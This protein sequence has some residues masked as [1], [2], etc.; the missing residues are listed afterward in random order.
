MDL[1]IPTHVLEGISSRGGF[2]D[3]ASK[4]KI[5]ILRNGKPL[6]VDRGGKKSQYFRYSDMI[7]GKHPESNPL[8]QDGDHVIVN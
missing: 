6:M 7:S 5:R 3:F 4:N 1:V 8:L 2:T